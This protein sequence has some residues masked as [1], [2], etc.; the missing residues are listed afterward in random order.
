MAEVRILTIDG[1]SGSGKGTIS[2]RIAKQ[3]GWH[4][5]DS[6]ALYRVLA[7]AAQNHGLALDDAES[8]ATLAA[9]LDVQFELA[10]DP[11]DDAVQ[12]EG[13]NVTAMLRSEAC[14]KAASQVAAIL[15][16]RQALLERQRAFAEPPGLV[17]DGR[18][19]GTVVFP[20]AQAKVFLTASVQ[21][22]AQRRY[23]QLKEKG[24]SANLADVLREIGER[25][26]RDSSR[27]VAPLKP[28]ENAIILDTTKLS[29][30]EVVDTVMGIVEGR[31]T[32]T[33]SGV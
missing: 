30:D 1:P 8:L 32:S 7:M 2:R 3:L 17:A 21:A 18:D 15:S 14:G 29:I 10:V 9:H 33:F 22:R 5:L 12:L 13:E 6:G 20:G 27:A 25:D 4:Y 11:A 26:E 23:N 24:L 31:P 16:V 28:A 19:M